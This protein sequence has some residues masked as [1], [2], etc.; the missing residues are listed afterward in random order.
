MATWSSNSNNGLASCLDD[1]PNINIIVRFNG[2]QSYVI[3]VCLKNTVKDIK[4]KLAVKTNK[5]VNDINLVIAG[6]MMDNDTLVE[7][8]REIT[9]N[10]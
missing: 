4:D 9:C 8:C 2:S 3:N 5:P 10:S 7:V 6:Q 1:F